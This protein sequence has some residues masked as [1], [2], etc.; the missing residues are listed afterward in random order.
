ME[1]VATAAP[2]T[3]KVYVAQ[4]Q[5][6]VRKT[7]S[8]ALA[9]EG[10]LRLVGEA[11]TLAEAVREA[12]YMRPHVVVVGAEMIGRNGSQALEDLLR[13]LPETAVAVIGGDSDEEWLFAAV[14]AG[15]SGYLP[16]HAPM[17]QLVAVIRAVAKGDLALPRQLQRG[18]IK[19]LTERRAEQESAILCL[20]RLTPQEQRVLRLLSEGSSNDGIADQLVISP[21][22]AR[23]HVQNIL[24]K[25]G[26][27]SRLEAV[28]FVVRNE[29]LAQMLAEAS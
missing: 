15:A 18:L 23:T 6:L 26:V 7:V 20:L 21:Q 11:G 28:A 8:M 16:R 4:E 10:D 9:R 27:H 24:N 14:T 1:L 22:T 12:V 5:S 17:S 3:L 25:L 19:R 13:Q 29:L 2:A